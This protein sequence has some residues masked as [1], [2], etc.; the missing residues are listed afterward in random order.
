MALKLNERLTQQKCQLRINLLIKDLGFGQVRGRPVLMQSL[1][2]KTTGWVRQGHAGSRGRLRSMQAHDPRQLPAAVGFTPDS[3]ILIGFG[4]AIVWFG[5]VKE[6]VIADE[7]CSV[8]MD[9]VNL[10]TAGDESAVDFSANIVVDGFDEVFFGCG[11]AASVVIEF[12]GV[13]HERCHLFQVAGII[14]IEIDAVHIGNG[15]V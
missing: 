14:G 4:P 11:E 15:I 12:K 5:M 3:N 10:E 1:F 6:L 2:Q 13:R 9:W 7:D 8:V